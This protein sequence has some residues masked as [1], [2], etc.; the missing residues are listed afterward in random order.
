MEELKRKKKQAR[1]DSWQKV[2]LILFIIVDLALAVGCIIQ[3]QR[4]RD[5]IWIEKLPMVN[6]HVTWEGAGYNGIWAR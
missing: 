4:R 3:E 2:I 5:S 1:F 6:Q